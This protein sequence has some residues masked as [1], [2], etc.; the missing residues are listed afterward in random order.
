G[1]FI[2]SEFPINVEPDPD[3]Q[4]RA[5]NRG[6]RRRFS[7][8]RRADRLP[9]TNEVDAALAEE[10]Y[11][12]P[13]WNQSSDGFRNRNEGWVPR[14][15]GSQLHNRVH[16]WVD[17]D[18]FPATSPNDPVF[19]LNHCNVDRIWDV[20]QTNNPNAGYRPQGAS[21]TTAD[22]LYRHRSD[23]PLYSIFTR[24]EPAVSAM[25]DVSNFYIYE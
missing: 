11:D 21:P 10:I 16:V 6:L 14:R 3:D 1:P 17:G 23:D 25:F 15:Q 19:Y 7:F 18:M 22:P 24:T 9:R 13:N 8:A 5:T 12:A 20:W 4:L 2:A